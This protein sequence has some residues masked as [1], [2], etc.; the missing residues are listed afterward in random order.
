MKRF[1]ASASATVTGDASRSKIPD[2]YSVSRFIRMTSCLSMAVGSR[3]LTSLRLGWMLTAHPGGDD[4]FGRS[5]GERHAVA[6]HAGDNGHVVVGRKHPVRSVRALQVDAVPALG[7]TQLAGSEKR[8]QVVENQ[9][10]DVGP[11]ERRDRV[12]VLVRVADDDLPPIVLRDE[13]VDAERCLR[14]PIA[15]ES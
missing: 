3:R 13:D 8:P 11:V 6:T 12:V 7:D 15:G 1:P 14:G 2:E 4:G 10:I 9:L 5:E